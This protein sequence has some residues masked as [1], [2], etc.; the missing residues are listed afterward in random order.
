MQV[1]VPSHDLL[2]LWICACGQGEVQKV[3]PCLSQVLTL[4]FIKSAMPCVGVEPVV[5][6]PVALPVTN[7]AVRSNVALA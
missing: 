2:L 5:P 6:Q 4:R 1:G 3:Q 7:H